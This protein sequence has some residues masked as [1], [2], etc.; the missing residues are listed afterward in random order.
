MA[1]V[2][3]RPN[4]A[5]DASPLQATPYAPQVQETYGI[6]SSCG[7]MHAST[8]RPYSAER[9]KVVLPIMPWRGPKSPLA[10]RTTSEVRCRHRVKEWAISTYERRSRRPRRNKWRETARRAAPCPR[11]TLCNISRAV[12]EDPGRAYA[13]PGFSNMPSWKAFGEAQPG[14]RIQHLE[15]SIGS[16]TDDGMHGDLRF[17]SFS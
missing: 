7:A 12:S 9:D 2:S 15:Q 5:E 16:Q 11:S 3:F 6:F 14:Q 1:W 8:I 10:R 17:R 4:G 13:A